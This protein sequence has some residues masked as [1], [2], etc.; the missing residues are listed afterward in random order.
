MNGS[1]FDSNTRAEIQQLRGRWVKDV[2][3][4]SRACL[5]FK[6]NNIE[7]D[8]VMSYTCQCEKA[9]NSLSKINPCFHVSLST[10]FSPLLLFQVIF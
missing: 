9:C 4:E 2:K 6:D 1:L 8:S 3:I 5:V 7:C 10:P